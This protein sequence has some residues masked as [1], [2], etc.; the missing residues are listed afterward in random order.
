MASSQS[1]SLISQGRT[2]RLR[3]KS[4]LA[5]PL[6]PEEIRRQA[7]VAVLYEIVEFPA[8]F[9]CSDSALAPRDEM[10]RWRFTP[11]CGGV[12]MRVLRVCLPFVHVK[13]PDGQRQ[14]IDV[15]RCQLAELGHAYA[16]AAWK[17]A[18]KPKPTPTGGATTL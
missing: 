7:Y 17:A 5:R 9:F 12:P 14:S 3:G 15:R 6:A 2:R 18:K 13:L 11:K 1:T 16:R 4:A 10:L 8:C